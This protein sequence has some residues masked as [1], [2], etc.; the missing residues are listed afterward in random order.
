MD[1]EL[2]EQHL[3]LA[4]QHVAQGRRHIIRQKQII[5]ELARGQHDTSQA[6]QLLSTFEELQLMHVAERNRLQKELAWMEPWG[7]RVTERHE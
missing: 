6:R 5:F 3:K 1:R 7:D 4:K 2:L